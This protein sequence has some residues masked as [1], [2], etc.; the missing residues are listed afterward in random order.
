MVLTKPL[1]ITDNKEI[2]IKTGYEILAINGLNGLKI[3]PLAKKVG[4]S[5]S[6]FYH[7]F[8]DLELFIDHLLNYHIEQSHIIAEKEQKANTIDPDL[9]KIIVEHKL[10][11]LFSR[12]LRIHRDQKVFCE[13]L[14]KSNEIVGN[15]FVLPWVRELNLNLSLKQ[16]QSIFE[17][18]LENFFLQVSV[19]NLNHQWLTHYFN[20]LKKV[21][22]NFVED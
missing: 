1:A 18:A 17:L 3:E 15:A 9:I 10:D 6:S 4:I 12:Q 13:V 2:W 5:K 8:A 16:L 7:H 19:D 21:I 22:R 20:H 11:I 14:L